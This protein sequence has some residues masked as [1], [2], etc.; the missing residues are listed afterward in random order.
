MFVRGKSIE[1]ESRLVVGYSSDKEKGMGREMLIGMGF[2]RGL[3][4]MF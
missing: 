2:L 4:K 1:I 3:K